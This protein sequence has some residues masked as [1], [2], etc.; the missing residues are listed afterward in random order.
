M[1]RVR[2]WPGR[3]RRNRGTIAFWAAVLAWGVGIAALSVLAKYPGSFGMRFGSGRAGLIETFLYSYLLVE[4]HH[5]WDIALIAWMWG[6]L[7]GLAAWAM[8]GLRFSLF[9][10]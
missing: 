8:R 9:D 2:R 4:R 7:L 5:W 3:L 6:P 1:R 10:E